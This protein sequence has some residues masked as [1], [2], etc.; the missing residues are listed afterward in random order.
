MTMSP[1]F[2]TALD[3][4]AL[5]PVERHPSIFSRFAQ[6]AGGESFEIVN[7]HD[8]LPLRRQLQALWPGQYD[9]Q[10]L[11]QGPA[12]WSVRISRKATATGCCGGCGGG[13]LSA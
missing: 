10:V 12:V 11:E 5:P 2:A 1:A 4:R 7:D 3:L 9:W 8:P 6:L 13:H